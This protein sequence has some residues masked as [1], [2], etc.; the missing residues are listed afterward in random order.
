MIFDFLRGHN[1][2]GTRPAQ[3]VARAVYPYASVRTVVRGPLK[4]LRFKVAPAMGFTY[5]WGIGVE[6][7]AFP[8]LVQPGMCVYDIGANCGQSTLS[9]AASVGTSGRVIAFEPVDRNFSNL[10]CNIELNPSLHVIP[11]NAAAA[12]KSG[13]LDFH[14]DVDLPTQ[15]HLRG[16][17]PTYSLPNAKTVRVRAIRLDDY[18]AET[19]PA[20]Q[21]MKIDVE[22]GA[23]AVLNGAQELIARH[24]PTIYVELHGPEEQQ[25]VRELLR[26]CGYRAETLSGEIVPDPTAGSFSPLVCKPQSH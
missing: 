19:W 15:G 12:E 2:G 6:Q 9:L 5:A 17:E 10:V 24:R 3:L 1:L 7:W 14:F 21:F 20:P 26:V 22:G 25:A 16:V 4:G 13:W 23:G 8:G 18:A 11:V